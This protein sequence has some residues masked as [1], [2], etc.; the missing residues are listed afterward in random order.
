M[1]TEQTALGRLEA[2]LARMAA[3]ADR[4]AGEQQAVDPKRDLAVQSAAKQWLP[5]TAGQFAALDAVARAAEALFKAHRLEMSA[6]AMGDRWR[7]L[8]AALNEWRGGVC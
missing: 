2:N 8:E 3:E 5:A 6:A 1:K 4:L 7:V